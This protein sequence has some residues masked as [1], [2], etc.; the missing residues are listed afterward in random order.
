[1]KKNFECIRFILYLCCIRSTWGVDKA[2][3]VYSL[4]QDATLSKLIE[5][6]LVHLN[7]LFL[8]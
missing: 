5:G 8:T 2:R 3:N 1:M 7:D 6:D 4:G